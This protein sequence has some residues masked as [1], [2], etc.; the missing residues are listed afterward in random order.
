MST[1]KSSS[2][3]IVKIHDSIKEML[4]DTDNNCYDPYQ[5]NFLSINSN[6]KSD[7]KSKHYKRQVLIDKLMKEKIPQAEIRKKLEI[8]SKPKD[9]LSK[10][11]I[12]EIFREEII[13]NIFNSVSL[14][15]RRQLK[16]DTINKEDLNIFE[17]SM[18]NT[19]IQQ[20]NYSMIDNNAIFDLC[21]NFSQIEDYNQQ[22]ST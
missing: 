15:I 4:A 12:K 20:K 8:E 7:Y 14:E 17:S 13:Q 22:N 21:H 2:A 19:T 5:R 16:K 6:D 1:I 18:N 10:E 3:N 11:I 9:K